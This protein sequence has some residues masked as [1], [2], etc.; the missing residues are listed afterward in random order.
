ME[1]SH[2][3]T[4][5]PSS[6]TPKKGLGTGAKIGIG[7][8]GLVVLII[9]GFIVAVFMLKGKIQ[10]FA[11]EAQKNPTRATASLMVSTGLGEMVAED[12]VNKRYT[13][14]EKK[15]GTLTTFYWNAK[16]NAPDNVPGDFSAIPVEPAAT[17]PAPEGGA[18]P[19]AI[20][21]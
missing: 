16:K 18:V 11:E 9:V 17:E 13:I 15:T 10:N 4:S 20:E 12:D 7:C 1:T 3:P 5:Q 6:P 14:K 19:D 2:S 8:G 21:K